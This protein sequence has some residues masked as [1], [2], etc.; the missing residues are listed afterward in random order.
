VP[1]LSWM[2]VVSLRVSH[3]RLPV[4]FLPAFHCAGTHPSPRY[5]P[6]A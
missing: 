2:F 5:S 4:V 3:R 1:R 6:V